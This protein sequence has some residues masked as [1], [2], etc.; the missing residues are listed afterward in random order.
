MEA[1]LQATD[2]PTLPGTEVIQEAINLHH[3]AAI[4]VQLQEVIEDPLPKLLLLQELQI[5]D[6]QH[7]QRIPCL[8]RKHLHRSLHQNLSLQVSTKC[9]VKFI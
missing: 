2:H 5:K 3:K 4:L 6:H 9:Y 7:L 1:P 8:Q